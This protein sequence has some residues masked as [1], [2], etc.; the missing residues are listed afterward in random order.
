MARVGEGRRGEAVLS[1][2]LQRLLSLA[3]AVAQRAGLNTAAGQEQCR[4]AKPSLPTDRARCVPAV[5]PPPGPHDGR[6][7]SRKE[8]C[9]VT[10]RREGIIGDLSHWLVVDNSEVRPGVGTTQCHGARVGVTES[11]V[12]RAR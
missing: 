10:A 8:G 6:P 7:G 9:R 4:C 2:E 1:E 5:R 12:F 3:A 11:I